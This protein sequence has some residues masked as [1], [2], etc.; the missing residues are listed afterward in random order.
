MNIIGGVH[1]RWLSVLFPI[2]MSAMLS[3]CNAADNRK[4]H[5]VYMGDLPRNGVT[6]AHHISLLETVLGSASLA[7]DSLVYSYGRSFNGFAAKLSP[8][9]VEMFSSNRKPTE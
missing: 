5:V 4:I 3:H 9:E 1:L 7:K 6:S 8:Q 2:L